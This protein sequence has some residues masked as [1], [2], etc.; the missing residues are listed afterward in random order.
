MRPTFLLNPVLA[1]LLTGCALQGVVVE[2]NFRPFPFV[3]S[4]GM[5]AIYKFKLRDP[6]GHICS[7]MVTPEV[8][9]QYEVGDYFNDLQSAERSRVQPE[10]VRTVKSVQRVSQHS[11]KR[12]SIAHVH[13]GKKVVHAHHA[14]K[15]GSKAQAHRTKKHPTKAQANRRAR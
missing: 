4:V 9:A 5:D 14:K 8:F 15:H 7:Q 11:G 2:K 3:D 12:S 1:A 10:D 13:H 6:Q